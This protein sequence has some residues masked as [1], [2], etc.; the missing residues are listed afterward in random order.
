MLRCLAFVLHCMLNAWHVL[1][2]R[3]LR[4]WLYFKKKNKN[5]V[6]KVV[7]WTQTLGLLMTWVQSP[8]HVVRGPF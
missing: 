1:G 8:F 6:N 2:L 4:G 5:Q 7:M 3:N